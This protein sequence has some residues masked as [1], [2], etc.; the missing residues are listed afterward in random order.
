MMQRKTRSDEPQ[1]KTQTTVTFSR[2]VVKRPPATRLD[3]ALNYTI[4]GLAGVVVV[5]IISLI[6][7]LHSTAPESVII[8]EDP[9]Q[10]ELTQN[11][12]ETIQVKSQAIRV[13]VLNGSGVP[14]LAAKAKDFLQSKGFD[15]VQTGNAPHTNYRKSIVQDRIGN[16]PNAVQVAT[17]LGISE[18]GVIQQK[19]PQRFVEVT[20]IIGA[21][22]KS[23]KFYND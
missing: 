8:N 23:L 19:N 10:S 20:V 2:Q 18:S 7:R 1:E 5:L 15:V 16:I 11:Q 17:A 21:D 9:G 22:Y 3:R 6:V 4:A 13:E 12:D 14:R